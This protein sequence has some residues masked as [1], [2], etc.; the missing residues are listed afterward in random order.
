MPMRQELPLPVPL[1][2][3]VM[4]RDADVPAS[5]GLLGVAVFCSIGLLVAIIAIGCG[6]QGVWL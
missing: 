3:A 6:V 5:D 1:T 4:A 2:V